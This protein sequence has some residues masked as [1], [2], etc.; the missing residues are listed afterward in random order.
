MKSI[1]NEFA[2]YPY[3]TWYWPDDDTQL[4]RVNS[5]VSDIDAIIK[6][7][8]KFD[9]CVQAGGACGVWPIRFAQF[10]KMVHTFEPLPENYECLVKNIPFENITTYKF[11]LSLTPSCHGIAQHENNRHN[12]GAYYLTHG[13]GVECIPIDDL[14]L[15]ACDLIQLDVEGH[16]NMVLGGALK[17]I[18]Q[19][20]PVIVIEESQMYHMPQDSHLIPRQILQGFGYKAVETLHKDVVFVYGH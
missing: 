19:F 20:K 13:E 14:S 16:E 18:K 6:H 17:T 9:V 5:Y 8:K 12:N 2:W 7:V 4:M 3:D 10:F 11:G 15:E 1:K